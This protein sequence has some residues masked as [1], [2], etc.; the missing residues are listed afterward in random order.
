APRVA[1]QFPAQQH[2]R[3]RL[4]H[5]LRLEVQPARHPERLVRRTRVAVDAAVLAPAVGIDR[6]TEPDVRA[7]DVIDD[8][9]GVVLVDL[10]GDLAPAGPLGHLSIKF[11]AQNVQTN[12][13][14]AIPGVQPCAAAADAAGEDIAVLVLAHEPNIRRISARIKAANR[15]EA[16]SLPCESTAAVPGAPAAAGA[17]SV[18]AG[19]AP[20]IRSTAV[21]RTTLML[22]SSSISTVPTMP[23]IF[24]SIGA[25]SSPVFG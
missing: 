21:W 9:A 6:P 19:E 3:I 2:R 1:L 5:D 20:L 10:G 11:L 7:V 18:G 4:G 15:R 14:E 17:G 12:A 24:P 8:G 25:K 23:T 13:V 22:R 16:Q